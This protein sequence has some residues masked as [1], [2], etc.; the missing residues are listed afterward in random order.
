MPLESREPTS[1][2]LLPTPHVGSRVV[3]LWVRQEHLR[4]STTITEGQTVAQFLAAIQVVSSDVLSA[5]FGSY[6]L[7]E[8]GPVREGGYLS[9]HFAAPSTSLQLNRLTP[10]SEKVIWDSDFLWPDVLRYLYAVEGQAV[11]VTREQ[12]GVADILERKTLQLDRYELVQGGRIPTQ[13]IVR[14]YLT[15][16]LI[17][18]LVAKRP[19]PQ[20]VIYSW[21]ALSNSLN[22]LHDDIIV[23]EVL[24]Q[25]RVID[26]FG[27]PNAPDAA[28]LGEQFFPRTNFLTW[29]SHIYRIEQS[30]RPVNGFYETVT[31]EA[32]PPPMPQGQ[33][34]GS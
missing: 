18:G 13:V 22:C 21:N 25:A 30:D 20:P 32:K 1:F 2:D 17:T 29:R 8:P 16:G 34:L 15:S 9:F 19:M 3:R 26:R 24:T 12:T 33:L 31:Y 28:A 11:D 14:R 5:G 4:S 23:P 27:T 10:W 7:T 6:V